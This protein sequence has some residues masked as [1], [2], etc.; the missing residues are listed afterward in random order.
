MRAH[1]VFN[2]VCLRQYR[3]D[4]RAQPPHPTL[5][6][7]EEEFIIDHIVDHRAKGRTH[8]YLVRWLGYGPEHNTW[9]PQKALSDTEAFERYWQSK[10]LEPPVH[11]TSKTAVKARTARVLTAAQELR[12]KP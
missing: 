9:E 4:G 3:T 6:D 5:V 8:E 11:A 2:V 1:N 10:G 7:G 12:H